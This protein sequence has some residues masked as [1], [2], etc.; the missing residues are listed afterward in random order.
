MPLTKLDVRHLIDD[1]QEANLTEEGFVASLKTASNGIIEADMFVDC[2]GFSS[3]LIGKALNVP[4]VNK[5]HQLFVDHALTVQIP[6]EDP[7]EEIPPYTISTAKESGWIWDIGLTNRRG[8]G[9]VYSSKYE[10]HAQAE[11]V[12][13]SYVG[14]A[15]KDLNT[16]LIPMKIGHREK[17]WVKNCVAVGLSAGF[18]EPLEATGLLVFDASGRALAEKFPATFADIEAISNQYNEQINYIWNRVIDFVKVHYFVSK[19]RDSEFWIDNTN[20]SSAPDSLL[21]RLEMWKH[22]PPSTYDFFSRFETFNL[23]NYLYMYF[24]A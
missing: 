1:V 8:I 12:L 22:A 2:S 20:P 7:E 23:E 16:R 11:K 24:M 13:E 6:Y 18:V 17:V 9:Y 15:I 5:G 21:S 19:R 3:L 14:P 10:D 4:F